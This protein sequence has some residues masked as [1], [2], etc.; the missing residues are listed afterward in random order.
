M[1]VTPLVAGGFHSPVAVTLLGCIFLLREVELAATRLEHLSVDEASETITWRLTAS[2]TDPQ[3]HGTTRT[4]GCLCG[5]VGLPCPFHLCRQVIRE[6]TIF[7]E[8]RGWSQ[9]D[10]LRMPLL[11]TTG[12]VVC[13]KEAVVATFEAL[14]TLCGRPVLSPEGL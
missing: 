7:A 1:E 9:D 6:A 2:K 10:M 5:A 3:A 8:A 4:W 12:G 14:A 13:T 11:Y